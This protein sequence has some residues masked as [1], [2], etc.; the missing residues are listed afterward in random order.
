MMEIIFDNK[1]IHE[2]TASIIKEAIETTLLKKNIA[3]LGLPGGRS[4]STVLKFLKMQDVEWKH[5]HVFLVDERLVQI[6]DKY[7]NFRLIKQAL[8]DVIPSENLHP[9]IF[10]QYK[11]D[12][13]IKGYEKEIKRY[14]GC[15][16]IVVVSSGEDGHIGSL[17]PDHPSIF[18]DDNYYILVDNSPKPPKRRMSISKKF[19]LKSDTGVLLFID[20]V[21]QEAYR[22]F[23]D[24]N[25]D[26]TSCPAKLVS[27][28]PKSFVVTNIKL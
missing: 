8:S 22:R 7:S 11:L 2:K 15:Y 5:V 21:K 20:E 9:F 6:N 3:V 12:L 18:N 25:I 4:I 17:F 14:G 26:F 27:M 16:D 13:G 19:L 24:Q 23:L 1:T 10:D 28:L